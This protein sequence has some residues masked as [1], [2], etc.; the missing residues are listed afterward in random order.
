[1]GKLSDSSSADLRSAK[2]ALRKRALALRD[3]STPEQRAEWSAHIC[4]HSIDLTEYKAARFIHCFLTIQTEVDTRALIEHALAHGKRVAI[5]LFVKGSTETPSCEI[6]S[7]A[8]EDFEPGTFGLSVPRM[9]RPVAPDEIDII[10]V[11]LTA[12]APRAQHVD[13]RVEGHGGRCWDRLG[14]G[15]GYYDRLLSRM[16]ACRAAL[17]FELQRMVSLPTGP[18]D[19]TLDHVITE[20]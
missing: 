15:V 9:L 13:A 1:M 8:P 19:Q 4:G 10:F 16:R 17:A 14:Y 18:A 12:F 5:P 20:A 6:T 2:R 7:L 11:S 3:A